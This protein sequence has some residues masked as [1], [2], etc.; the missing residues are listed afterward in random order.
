VQV[1]EENGAAS[2]SHELSLSLSLLLDV[3][4]GAA[5]GDAVLGALQP[6]RLLG[7][8][9]SLQGLSLLIGEGCAGQEEDREEEGREWG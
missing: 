5:N 8:A 1:Q 2:L 7:G 6:L 4:G 9:G 3:G